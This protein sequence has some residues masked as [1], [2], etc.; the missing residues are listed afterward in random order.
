MECEKCALKDPYTFLN[1]SYLACSLVNPPALSP[2]QSMKHLIPLGFLALVACS[3]P[4]E[5]ED[6]VGAPTEDVAPQN[7]LSDDEV[8]DGWEL[9]FDG[10]SFSGW[11][12]YGGSAIEGSGW[13]VEHD[14]IAF[15]PQPEDGHDLT[16]DA[17]YANFHLSLEWKISE[18][19]NSGIMFYVKEDPQYPYPWMTGPEMQVLDHGSEE[20]PGHADAASS[21]HRAGD[22]YDLVSCYEDVI[23]PTG[24]WNHAEIIA[25]NGDITFKMN[26]VVVVETTMWDE[27][28]GALVEGSKFVATPDF[29]TFSSGKLCLQDHGSQVWYRNIKIKRL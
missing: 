20:K 2:L 4:T 9:L 25:N 6:A 21:K 11:H 18:G 15:D 27:E 14:A 24:E 17:E 23:H 1:A 7:F 8:L 19:G 5:D 10:T 28:W 16:S 3:S 12:I 29:G 22:L 13:K 26:D